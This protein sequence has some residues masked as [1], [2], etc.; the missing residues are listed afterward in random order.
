VVEDQS[1]SPFPDTPSDVRGDRGLSFIAA[2]KAKKVREAGQVVIQRQVVEEAPSFLSAAT[3]EEEVINIFVLGAGGAS[4]RVRNSM[5]KPP[6][7]GGE[8]ASFCKPTENFTLQRSR[9]PPNQ[10]RKFINRQV[11]KGQGVEIF[12]RKHF[13]RETAN[14][15]IQGMRAKPRG[16]ELG[17]ESLELGHGQ[18]RKTRAKNMSDA[19]GENEGHRGIGFRRVRKEGGEAIGQGEVAHPKIKPEGG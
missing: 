4:S 1:I 12:I 18:M 10:C 7:I 3:G 8:M 19:R 13:V 6:R 14:M 5:P 11:P 15:S 16:L 17:R 9:T 2:T